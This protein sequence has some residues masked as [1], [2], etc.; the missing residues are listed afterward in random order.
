LKI[1]AATLD[2]LLHE[3]FERLIKSGRVTSPTK[4]KAFESSG[5]ILELTNPR[6]RMSR[7]ETRCL[8]FSC[9]GELLW[10]LS[11]SDDYS[12]IKYYIPGYEADEVGA[13]R[14]R[15]AYGP[16]LKTKK[17]DQI[18][19]VVKL[20]KK[21]PE[22]RRAVIPIF[23]V[24]DTLI[25]LPEVPCTCT[26]QFLLRYGRLEMIT[27]MRSNDA[28]K[29]LPGDI[30]TF[31]MIQEL[32]ARSLGAE[33]GKYKHMVGSLHLYDDDRRKAQ[34]FLQEG[35]QRKA[36]MPIMPAGD[37][38][39]HVLE[40]LR[41]EALIRTGESAQTLSTFPIYWQDLAQLLRIFRATT[42]QEPSKR[43]T[44]LRKGMHS[45]VFSP[46]IEKRHQIAQRLEDSKEPNESQQL[47]LQ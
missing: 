44:R 5:V 43:I 6:A 7:T 1:R 47:L 13:P 38:S 12:F 2:D 41:I 40:L 28:F 42:D 8:L 25:D 20:L 18:A 23:Q 16:R 3:A 27:H 17:K 34:R 21:K 10:Y 35:W 36:A 11:G 22:T 14:V 4:G 24:Q 46:Y 9:L 26:L 39:K 32:V 31:T 37:Q 29:G 33:L 15:A 45:D 30:F 19:W